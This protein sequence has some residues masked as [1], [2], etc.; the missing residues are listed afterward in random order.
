MRFCCAQFEGRF[1]DAGLRGTGILCY[2]SDGGILHFVIQHRALNL[3]V[4]V[5]HSDTPLSFLSE[6]HI[7]YCP[8]CGV[9]L[10]D[11]YRDSS[12]AKRPD[13]LINPN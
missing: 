3:N 4:P 11:F 10:R 13:L 2:C 1:K 7:L 6:D 8:W 12:I 9:S 5:P